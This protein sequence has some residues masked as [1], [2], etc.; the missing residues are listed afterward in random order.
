MNE[1]L[2]IPPICGCSPPRAAQWQYLWQGLTEEQAPR[3]GLPRKAVPALSLPDPSLLALSLPA[4]RVLA[5]RRPAA[6]FC[7]FGCATHAAKL[8]LVP[9][10]NDRNLLYL[11]VLVIF[12]RRRYPPNSACPTLVRP[13]AFRQGRCPRRRELSPMSPACRSLV[14]VKG[15]A[16]PSP[17]VA[18]GP[19]TGA[20]S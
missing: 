13:A 18:G 1:K 16:T 12:L 9:Q 17:G 15:Q 4:P 7:S 11:L 5:Q 8:R 2:G 10:A 19:G 6:G 14:L 20:A 3:R